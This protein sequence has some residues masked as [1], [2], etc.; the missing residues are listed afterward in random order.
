MD[1]TKFL[2]KTSSSGPPHKQ[3]FKYYKTITID[4]NEVIG[5]GIHKNFPILISINDS[6]LYYHA[7]SD[8][9]DIAFANDTV[10]LD[11]EIELFNPVYNSTYVQLIVWIR[12][13]NLHTSIDTVIYMYY[14]NSTM[15]PQENP[16]DVWGSNFKGV[17][18]LSEDPSSPPPQMKESSSNN[19]HG[20]AVNLDPD[21][22]VNGQIDGSIDFDSGIKDF[23]YCGDN[24][25]LN[26]GKGNFSLSLWFKYDGVNDGFLAAKG[27]FISGIRYSI[28]I[29]AM[30]RLRGEINDGTISKYIETSFP[31]DDNIW[32]HVVLVKDWY[33][34]RLYLDGYEYALSP[35]PVY[36]SLDNPEP[37]YINAI[38]DFPGGSPSSSS[39]ASLDEVRVSNSACSA[40]WVTTE[41]NNQYDPLN[42]FTID[43][44]LIVDNLPPNYSNLIESADPIELGD[45]E[46]I[47]INVTDPSG[48]NQVKIEF[49]S[50]N[51][52][53]SN[54]GGDTWQ[55]D[56]W[57][58]SS[59][60][61]YSYTIWM[62]DNCHNWNS[63][64]GSIEVIDSTP[65]TYSNLIE[66][67]DPLQLG[68]NES[69][70]IKVYD[71]PGSGVNQVLLEYA[72]TPSGTYFNHTMRLISGNTWSWSN[73]KP[74]LGGDYLY[75]VYM[76]D[77]E[78]NWNITTGII[79]VI[80]T[81]AP[82]IENLTESVDPLELGDN[83]T[84]TVDV[85]DIETSV[86]TVFIEL[87]GIN[88]TMAYIGGYSYE[89]TWTRSLVG[90]VNYEIYA[91][92]TDNNW[93]SL[94]DTFDIVDTTPPAFSGLAKSEDPLEFGDTIIISVNSTDLSDINQVLIEF[95]NFN[96][97]M[98]N[99]EGNMWQYDLWSPSTTGILAFTIWAQDNNNNWNF[100][101]D[102]ILVQDT[103]PPMYSDLFESVNPVELGS[104]LTISIN[105]TDLANIKGVSIEYQNANHT[106]IN[107]GG[108]IWQYS[109]WIPNSIGNYS[110]TIYII[111]NND[112][113]N[114]LSSSILFQDT[115]I[116]IYSNMYESADPLELGDNQ[117]IRLNVYDFAGINQ[118]LIEFEG[119]NHSMIN[120]YGDTWQFDTWIP[121]NWIF[122][123]YRIHMEDKSGN[124]NILKGNI[125]VQDTIPP[126]P[127]IFVSNNQGEVVLPII[128]DWMDGNDPSGISMYRLIIDNEIDPFAT[129]GFVF[130]IN[131]TNIGP[132]G[133]YYEYTGP[134]QPGTYYF[135]LYQIDG[136]GHQ[137]SASMGSFSIRSNSQPFPI[138]IIL[139]SILIISVLASLTVRSYVLLPRKR[140]KESEL[141]ARTQRF[142]DLKNIQAIIIIQKLSGVPIF[143]KSYSILEKNQN[144]LFSG[145]IQAITMISEEFSENESVDTEMGEKIIELDLKH[146]KCLI[147]DEGDVRVAFVLKQKH[148]ERLKRQ[149]RAFTIALNLNLFEELENWDGSLDKFRTLIPSILNEY[150][151]L[152]YK[153]LFTI[154]DTASRAKILKNHELSSMEKHILSI[155]D[156]IMKDERSFYL[157]KILELLV[158]KNENSVIDALESLIKTELI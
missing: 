152:Y 124:W 54:I 90:T 42:F 129:P 74:L 8:G 108:D 59:V 158:E 41:Y 47:S 141:L 14:G 140:R 101:S 103:I 39:S 67:A 94:S 78:D 26:M 128:F 147:T 91:N 85:Y 112:N 18:H 15:G 65:P 19:N 139:I 111:D 151:E 133:S 122:Y 106:M 70:S 73:W 87:E 4:H 116:P 20:I 117:I 155:I 153:G 40:G 56:S 30:D 84:I 145:F 2:I 81:T 138:W 62:E 146:F 123:Q 50:L 137:S 5:M 43:S 31:V 72:N 148:S 44:E 28:W 86:S 132:S 135:C 97:S 32:H 1:D 38:T 118:S 29:T 6:D 16:E 120:I 10:W 95:E 9:D 100:Y 35:I 79:T 13:P 157:D 37:F 136:A 51:H 66:S 142:K 60:G 46:V 83:I 149:I 68:Q 23:I 93:N 69:I 21:D 49:E 130:D 71:S 25:S 115:V 96:H 33:F 27:A 82:F 126:S 127:P 104:P 58:P 52:T 114:Y 105:C 45:I 61:N 75:K 143:S 110:Y 55:Y 17:W 77:L 36:G 53:M 34:L 89:Y 98:T 144:E 7:Q 92:D 76:Q 113:L 154:T 131:I 12:I 80:S 3:F 107:I 24:G 134:L 109:S 63:T 64:I 156:S 121:N 150:F 102:S 88:N 11:H 125:T 99:I 57:T 48:I 119:T 22:Q